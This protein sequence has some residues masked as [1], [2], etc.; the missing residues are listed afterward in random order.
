MK[1][2]EA[3]LQQGRKAQ[4]QAK[5]EQAINTIIGV[6][7]AQPAYHL[8]RLPVLAEVM[9]LRGDSPTAVQNHLK[10]IRDSERESSQSHRPAFAGQALRKAAVAQDDPAQQKATYR[11]AYETW[12]RARA[13]SSL[14]FYA[15][16]Q[17]LAYE[18]NPRFAFKPPQEIL[19]AVKKSRSNADGVV[20]AARRPTCRS[21]NHTTTTSSR[22]TPNPKERQLRLSLFWVYER[23]IKKRAHTW[24][25][26][27]T[28]AHTIYPKTPKAI[29]M[30]IR[31][32]I[33]MIIALFVIE[34]SLVSSA[35]GR[36]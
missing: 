24:L 35:P 16:R 34:V 10:Q 9:E 36:W 20:D 8:Q 21:I 29:I 11:K 27:L 23:L 4:A 26:P 17:T 14:N 32:A 25:N 12:Y 28:T 2:G 22:S 3:L 19:D 5:F 31:E 13:R 6:M 15:K 18:D 33:T 1:E 7:N 30:Q